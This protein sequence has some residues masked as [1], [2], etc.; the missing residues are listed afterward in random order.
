M[1]VCI[2]IYATITVSCTHKI[3]DDAIVPKKL[4]LVQTVV[5]MKAYKSQNSKISMRM[6]A[7]LME[8]YKV[9]NTESYDIFP[10]KFKVYGYD[11]YGKLE[12]EIRADVAKHTL[13][14]GEEEWAAFGNV[15]ITNFIKKERIETDTLYWDQKRKMIYT[16]SFVKIYSPDGFMQGYGMKSDERARNAELIRPFDSFGIIKK[17]LDNSKNVNSANF[18]SPLLN[19]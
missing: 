5:D 17:D 4:E 9:S 1:V 8:K 6:E 16:H 14:K 18:N 3:S 7:K 19:R 15:V 2:I 11:S 10:K 12:T 13:N